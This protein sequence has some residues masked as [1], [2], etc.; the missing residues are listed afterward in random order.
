VLAKRD[1]SIWNDN[2]C[3]NNILGICSYTVRILNLWSLKCT[4]YF[5]IGQPPVPQIIKFIVIIQ[6]Q[7]LNPVLLKCTRWLR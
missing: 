1:A 7:L 3:S 4:L 2:S 5:I 6:L